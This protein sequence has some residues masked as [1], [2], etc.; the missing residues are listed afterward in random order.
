MAD[1]EYYKYYKAMN[2][3]NIDLAFKGP[4]SHEIL[5]SLADT[6]MDSLSRDNETVRIAKKVFAIF[7]ELTQN[8]RD[9]SSE[10]MV[11]NGKEVGT[12]L[13]VLQ[14][15]EDYFI[16]LSGNRIKNFEVDKIRDYVNQ[17]NSL[18]KDELKQLYKQK[19]SQ[20]RAQENGGGVGFIS[21]L[22]KSESTLEIEMEQIDEEFSFFVVFTK[23]SKEDING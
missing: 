2:D 19:L 6:L 11:F 18:D 20:D 8:I 12:G 10:V 22:R 1:A 16:L 15:L 3:R 9:Y 17:L 21:I 4:F 14:E 13:I 5:L 7:V 23:I